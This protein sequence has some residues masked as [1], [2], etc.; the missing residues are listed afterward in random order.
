MINFYQINVETKL[1]KLQNADTIIAKLGTPKEEDGVLEQ[2]E[3]GGTCK[4]LWV[5]RHIL[6]KFLTSAG[7]FSALENNFRLYLGNLGSSYNIY[8]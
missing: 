1:N 6:R 5:L 7:V 8:Q 3:E 4:M 2:V